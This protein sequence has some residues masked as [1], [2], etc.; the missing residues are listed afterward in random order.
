MPVRTSNNNRILSANA[1]NADVAERAIQEIL[2]TQQMRYQ[3]AF[4][5]QGFQG[6]LYNRLYQGQ[7]C[8]CKSTQKHLASRLDESGKAKP[9]VLNEL[10]TGAVFDVSGYGQSLP[11]TDP[12]DS[13]TS[14]AAP[15][16]KHQGDFDIVAE[17]P[18][19]LPTRVPTGPDFG[20]NGPLDLG[21]D[22]D[23]LASDF[24][25]SAIGMTE[26]ACAVCFGSGFVGGYTPLYGRRIVRTV[27]QV[28]LTSTDAIDALQNPWRATSTGFSFTEIL[29]YGALAVDIFRVLCDHKPVAANFTIDGQ[30]INEVTVLK[31][32][33]GR[34]HLVEVKF[35]EAK[36]WTHVE[37]QF[38][39]SS[40]IAF[41]EFPKLNKSS[42]TS[43]LD[44]TEP[45]Q[46]ILSPLIP[47]VQV[48]DLF[49]ES[50]TGKALIVQ[51]VNTWNTRQ[52]Q[53]L[54]WECQVR[55]IQEPEIYNLI[56]RRG[57]IKTKPETSN[58][59]HDNSTGYR[60]T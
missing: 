10:L 47:T 5:V 32:C 36:V 39:T 13:V 6:V 51:S 4:R 44:N 55:V 30:P 7:K 23:E 41:F 38:A 15:V 50:T 60:R 34:P 3:S 29:P 49:T 56:P 9:G 20:D 37:I 18:L 12:F 2:P 45:F 43:L 8:T 54:G 26:V 27:D 24:D 1:R 48:E 22:I 57:R 11:R 58:L 33:D 40:D 14:P 46:I 25:A 28:R 19:S 42:D 16:N 52:R 35:S 21:F 17:T 59:V 31:Y 53:T